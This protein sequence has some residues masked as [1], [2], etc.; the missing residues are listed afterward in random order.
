MICASVALSTAEKGSSRIST[1]R[2]S[3]ERFANG[4]SLGVQKKGKYPFFYFDVPNVEPE[5]KIVAK[6][7]ELTDESIIRKVEEFNQDYV[8][9][10]E[11]AVI[12]W[13][14][15]ETPV[16]YYSIN[17]TLGDILASFRGKLYALKFLKTLLGAYSASGENADKKEK[18]NKGEKASVM[19][20]S[21]NKTMIDMA[22]GFSVKRVLMMLGGKFTKEQI[23]EINAQLNKIKKPKKVLN[24]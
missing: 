8:M 6:A 24:K 13:F 12:N 4:E 19:G 14:E 3:V 16:G 17:D 2:R 9:K 18:K 23:L 22:K 15:I 21:I 20:F 10:E 11:G 7:G 5:T 1:G